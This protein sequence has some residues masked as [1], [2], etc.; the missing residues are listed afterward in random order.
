MTD[1]ASEMAATLRPVYETARPA[2][3]TKNQFHFPDSVSGN[4]NPYYCLDPISATRLIELFYMRSE[5]GLLTS[6][7]HDNLLLIISLCCHSRPPCSDREILAFSL[8][9]SLIHKHFFVSSVHL[10]THQAHKHT[11]TNV[12]TDVQSH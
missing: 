11:N 8:S 2:H 10:H 4:S 9:L 6:S 12:R 3:G 1:D 5:I 7:S